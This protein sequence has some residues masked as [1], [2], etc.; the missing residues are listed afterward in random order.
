[1]LILE[2]YNALEVFRTVYGLVK[3]KSPKC[4]GGRRWSSERLSTD[5]GGDS[6]AA[7]ATFC[8]LRGTF[9]W[10]GAGGVTS[11]GT[12]VGHSLDCGQTG[13]NTSAGTLSE[14]GGDGSFVF[15]RWTRL[16]RT[17]YWGVSTSYDLPSS[18]LCTIPLYH[19]CLPS[20]KGFSLTTSPLLKGSTS[21]QF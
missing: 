8:L 1:M 7:G 5:L 6:A 20:W 10:L 21:P 16:R 12:V 15:S 17:T 9:S 11:L 18:R 19:S 14:D 3:V 4:F 13:T 2:L